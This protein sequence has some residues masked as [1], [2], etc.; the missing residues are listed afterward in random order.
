[1]N[2]VIIDNITYE[3]LIPLNIG[4]YEYLFLLNDNKLCYVK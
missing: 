2:N 1:M 4:K 3:K